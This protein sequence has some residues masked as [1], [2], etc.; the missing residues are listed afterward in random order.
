[1][2]L[3]KQAQTLDRSFGKSSTKIYKTARQK[4]LE[5]DKKITYTGQSDKTKQQQKEYTKQKHNRFVK[6]ICSPKN[7][8][9][10]L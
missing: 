2:A 5:A 3:F 9:R 10:F 6:S 4:F 7:I 1:M 8:D